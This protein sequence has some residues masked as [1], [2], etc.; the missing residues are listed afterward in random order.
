MKKLWSLLFFLSACSSALISVPVN[1]P[2]KAAITLE[3]GDPR[4]GSYVSSWDGF[5]TSSYWIEGPTGLILIDSQFLL[6][7]AAEFVDFAERTTGKKAVLAI[8]L[9]PNPDK[10]N[11]T[12]VFQRR[13]IRVV[14]SAEVLAAIPAVH[15]LRTEWFYERFKPDYPAV[16]PRPESFGSVTTDL[17]AG[18]ITVKARVLGAGCSSAHVV[19]E[20]DGHV[21]VGDL[22]TQGFHSWLELGLLEEWLKRLDEIAALKP[23]VV[24]TGRGGSGADDLIDREKQ[25][26]RSV[27]KIVRAHHP[28]QGSELSDALS[29]KILAEIVARYPAYDYAK[30]VENGLDAVWAKQRR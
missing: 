15:K 20:Y 8:I 13:G 3:H 29:A 11:G 12:E 10:F 18:G 30:F 24:H 7:A 23:S 17:T 16:E 5:H 4:V 19:V 27:I 22:V 1:V 28:R 21:F 6:S 2:V 26:L 14:T 9:H 25:Y